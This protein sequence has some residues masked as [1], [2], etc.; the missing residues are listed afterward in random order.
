MKTSVEG[1]SVGPTAPSCNEDP[2]TKRGRLIKVFVSLSDARCSCLEDFSVHDDNTEN[3]ESNFE[4]S[5]CQ[6]IQQKCK[7]IRQ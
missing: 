4:K 7:P 5:Q 6:K 1:I 3:V 2:Y